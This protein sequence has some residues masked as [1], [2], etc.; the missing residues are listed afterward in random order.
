MAQTL[1]INRS[2]R[3]GLTPLHHDGENIFLILGALV[4]GVFAMGAIALLTL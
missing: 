3:S 2:D 4:G 1:H